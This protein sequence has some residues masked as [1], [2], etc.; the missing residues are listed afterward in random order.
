MR[1]FSITL[2]PDIAAAVQDE[3][4][5]GDY[6]SVSE[7]VREGVLALMERDT[8]M[9]SWLSEDV[10]A[11]HLENLADPSKGVPSGEVLG[12]IKARRAAPKSP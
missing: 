10:V 12:R 6:A 1:R 7:V 8:A 4:R 9:E 2:P 11:G 5:S 3:V